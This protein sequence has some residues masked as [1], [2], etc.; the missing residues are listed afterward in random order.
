GSPTT[1]ATRAKPSPAPAGSPPKLFPFRTRVS[2]SSSHHA[3]SSGSRSKSGRLPRLRRPADSRPPALVLTS[4]TG[5]GRRERRASHRTRS[6]LTTNDH[7]Y[8]RADRVRARADRSAR[9]SHLG[10]RPAVPRHLAA[11]HGTGVLVA[12]RRTAPAR[13]RGRVVLLLRHHAGAAAGPRRGPCNRRV[14]TST[15][16]S[17]RGSSCSLS[18]CSQKR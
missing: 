3:A 9:R 15:G 16:C 6:T 13:D 10:D 14:S 7:Q 18:A 1:R 2:A 17:R 11:P 5:G 4:T 8:P 12:V